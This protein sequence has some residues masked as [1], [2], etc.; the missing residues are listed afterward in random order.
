MT[1]HH[2]L[3]IKQEVGQC[4]GQLSLAHTCGAQEQEAAAPVQQENTA[5]RARRGRV[6]RLVGGQAGGGS[7]RRAENWEGQT[8][9]KQA[10]QQT[11]QRTGRPTYM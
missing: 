7:G 2:L 10:G 11:D 3:I 9:V 8:V 5:R 4:L 6:V 1:H